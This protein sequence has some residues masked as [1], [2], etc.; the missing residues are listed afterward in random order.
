MPTPMTGEWPEK[1]RLVYAVSEPT[2]VQME[3]V[4]AAVT[5]PSVGL[6]DLE[7]MLKCLLPTMPAQSPTPRPAPT[8]IETMLKCLLP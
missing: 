4:V 5:G 2:R 8:D 1:A 7:A 3:Q 6:V